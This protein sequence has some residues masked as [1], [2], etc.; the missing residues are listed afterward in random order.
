MR[1][2]S[3]WG[4]CSQEIP[5][6]AAAVKGST[7]APNALR[8]IFFTG[9]VDS[10][11]SLLKHRDCLDRLVFV[12]GFD[13]GL[14]DIEQ[15]QLVE[16]HL[17]D[18][19]KRLGK[20]LLIVSTNLR[21]LAD[22]FLDWATRY[23]GAG[24]A[25]VGL[26]LE[27]NPRTLLIPSSFRYADVIPWGSHPL[28]DPLWSTEGCSFVHDGN[29]ASRPEKI[30]LELARSEV[31]LAHLRVCWESKCGC[32][33]CGVCEKCL[34]TML[35]LKIANALD[36]CATLRSN[37]SPD[38]FTTIGFEGELPRYFIGE[39]LEA[40]ESLEQKSEAEQY[41]KALIR[42]LKHWYFPSVRLRRLLRKADFHVSGGLLARAIKRMRV[43]ATMRVR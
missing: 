41:R 40:L 38:D 36:L 29:E 25:S 20:T 28:V 2:W 24:L 37:L 21:A 12:Q 30:R 11:Y 5:I 26:A 18:V 16:S 33:N 43:N 13:I 31:A 7:P 1:I 14:T 27:G 32:Y 17:E 39:N 9:G 23:H 4:F 8:A 15:Y 3:K 42:V 19:A 22:L 35:S 34:R 10:F 6:V